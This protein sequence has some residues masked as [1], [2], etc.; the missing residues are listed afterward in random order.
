M[1]AGVRTD[2]GTIGDLDVASERRGIRHDDFASDLAI[3][4]DVAAPA[5][6]EILTP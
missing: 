2:V 1:N 4:R 3:V 6:E 5:R